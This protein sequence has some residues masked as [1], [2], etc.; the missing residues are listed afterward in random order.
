M[1]RIPR[2]S[3]LKIAA[4]ALP[5][6]TLPAS[7]LLAQAPAAPL[8]KPVLVAAGADRE[9]KTHAVG[10]SSTTYKVL[11][12]DPSGAMF[13]LEQ[14]NSKKGGPYRH[15]HFS[16]DE[17]FYVLEGEYLIEVGAE[18]FHLKA[19]DCVLGPRGIPHVW[20]FVGATKGRMLLTYTPAGR[21]EEYFNDLKPGTYAPTAQADTMKAYGMQLIDGPPLKL[22]DPA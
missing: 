16:Q 10:V 6:S 15:L 1:N 11:T 8:V 9:G 18:Q 20:A 13:A 7:T 22:D 5:A 19:G 21:M 12:A 14:A 17:L 4:T 2:R 3:F